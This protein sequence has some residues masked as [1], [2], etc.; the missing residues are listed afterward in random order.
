MIRYQKDPKSD[1]GAQYCIFLQKIHFGS[2]QNSINFEV[3]RPPIWKK[4]NVL[5]PIPE[6]PKIQFLCTVWYILAKNTL[7]IGPKFN[8]FWSCSTANPKIMKCFWSDTRKTRNP[9]LVHSMV[10]SCKK[11]ASNGSK[12]QLILNLIDRQS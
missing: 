5:D 12:I 6:K 7:R 10:Y 3:A 8:Y 2:V 4:W 1:F 9:I 11:Y